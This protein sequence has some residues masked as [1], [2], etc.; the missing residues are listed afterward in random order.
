M[1]L[2]QAISLI[3]VAIAG[4]VVVFTRDP[5][6]QTIVLAL[7]GSLLTILFVVFQAPTVA[8][9][10]ISISSVVLPLMILLALTRIKKPQ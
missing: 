6:S 8:L 7:Y 2:S 3:L 4:T 5:L 1:T 10:E 9:S